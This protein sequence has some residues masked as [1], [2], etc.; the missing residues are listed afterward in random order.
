[1][2]PMTITLLVASLL[3]ASGASASVAQSP[4]PSPTS[5]HHRVEVSDAGFAL[6]FPG[7]WEIH[8]DSSSLAS[9]SGA[10]VTGRSPGS[11][12]TC[13]VYLYDTCSGEPFGDC[14]AVLD[15][16]AARMVATYESYE[17]FA[18][19]IEQA[20]VASAAEYA[21]RIDIEWTADAA[22]GTSYVLTD[23]SVHDAVLCRGS[24]RPDDRWLSI[25]E[26]VE[27]LPADE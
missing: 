16:F 27:F 12:V 7:D 24:E 8:F 5:A 17:D 3:L 26:T 9:G 2:L 18:G 25:A 1:M 6:T 11:D 21:V 4:S 23:G 20:P 15:E 14:A 22:F 19:A 13:E 10:V